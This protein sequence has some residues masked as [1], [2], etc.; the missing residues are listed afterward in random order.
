MSLVVATILFAAVFTYLAATFDYP[1][2]LNR[3]AS[4]V[5][6]ALLGLGMT[7]RSVWLV[8]GLIPLLLVPA[9]LGVNAAV[10]TRAPHLGRTAMWLS[11][12]AAASM[13]TGLLRWS[14]LNWA[15]AQQWASAS[16]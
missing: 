3:P 9:G 14:T 2:V 10:R 7:G 16:T 5:L 12:A 13:M 11:V 6:P 15:L 4:D 1:E 8:Y